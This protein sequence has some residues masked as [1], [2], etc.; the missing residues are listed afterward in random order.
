MQT[1]HRLCVV[2]GML[3]WAAKYLAVGRWTELAVAGRWNVMWWGSV[4]N[5]CYDRGEVVVDRNEIEKSSLLLVLCRAGKPAS[6]VTLCSVII[7]HTAESVI[8]LWLRY[9]TCIN[10]RVHIHRFLLFTRLSSFWNFYLSTSIINVIFVSA[11]W[12]IL[13]YFSLSTYYFVQMIM[14]CLISLASRFDFH[15]SIYALS[16]YM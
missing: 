4:P 16:V 10:S 3:L 5:V 12:F 6:C 11:Y 13:A 2:G 1:T 8:I 15:F 14:L 9:F 7:C